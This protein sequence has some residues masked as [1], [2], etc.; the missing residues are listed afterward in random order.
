M[1][2]RMT[3]A[4]EGDF[5]QVSWVRWSEST[6]NEIELRLNAAG[7]FSG[8][9]QFLQDSGTEI[10]LSS[11]ADT[12]SPGINVPYNIASRHGSNFINGAVDGV[13]LTANTTPVALPDLSATDLRLGQDFMG[14]IKTFRMWAADL[15]DTGI[16]EASS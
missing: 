15:G 5:R 13:A 7:G 1:E 8:L 9:V 4:D 14:T 2:G 3:Y 12:Y 10:A 6:T 16:A 11:G